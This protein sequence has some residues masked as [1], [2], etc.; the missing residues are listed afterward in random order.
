[1]LLYED[2][3]YKIRK[4][5]F[6]VYNYWGLGLLEQI[7]EESL[8]VE[9]ASMGMKV[10]RQKEI[11]IVYNGT[12]LQCDYR[13]DLLVEDEIIVELKSVAE[14]MDIHKKQLL[15]YLRVTGKKV[16]LLVNFNTTNIIQSILRIAN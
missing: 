16:G 3:T 10:E 4:A 7:Y 11:P 8:V 6:N 13:L 15:T 9:L 12:K 1:M 5:I 14:I 2:L